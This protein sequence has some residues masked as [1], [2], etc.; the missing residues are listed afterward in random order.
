V[1]AAFRHFE[2][3][4]EARE[5]AA[6]EEFAERNRRWLDDYALFRALKERFNFVP[7]EE[8]P[9]EL[10][11]REPQALDAA[12]RAMARPVA[13]HV[14]WP[15]LD[16]RQWAEARASGSGCGVVLGVALACW[17][18]R[19]CGAVWSRDALLGLE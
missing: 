1:E 18:S 13:R 4:G 16:S 7:W 2:Q 14:S 12:R 17:A 3:R 6:V 19:G 10:R 5:R 11:E 15:W 9:A 8:W